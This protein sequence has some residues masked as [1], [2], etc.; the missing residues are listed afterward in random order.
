V[1]LLKGAGRDVRSLPIPLSGLSGLSGVSGAV[2]DEGIQALALRS[3]DAPSDVAVRIEAV[4]PDGS[5]LPIGGFSTRS[6]WDQR[7]WLERPAALPKG[8]RVDVITT[9]APT[10]SLR[11]WI[12]YLVPST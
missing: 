2:I 8:T 6:G 12:E 3:V 4:S 5:R 9:G 7:Y 1:Y 11:L 10:G